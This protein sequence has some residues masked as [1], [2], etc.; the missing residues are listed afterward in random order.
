[1]SFRQVTVSGFPAL[2]LRGADVEAIVA[3]ALG[4]KLTNLRRLRGREWLWRSDQIPLA[5]GAPGASYVE[6]ADSGGWDECFP[7]VGP[8]PVPGAPD[9]PRLPDHGELWSARWESAVSEHAGGTTLTATTTG[10]RF[11]YEFQRAITL[12]AHEPIV[13]FRYRLRHLGG[14]PF[15]WIWSSHPLFN[16]QPGTTL[17]LPG[18]S[19]VRVDAAHGRPDAEHGDTLSWPGAVSGESTSF[20]VPAPTAGWALKLFA[21]VGRSGEAILTD[22]REGERLIFRMDPAAVPQIGVWIN[23]GGW[24]PTGRTPYFNMAVEPC[25]GAPDRLDQAVREWETAQLLGPGEERAWGLEV[26][27]PG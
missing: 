6:T 9:A 20:T 24:A 12:D 7:T 23:C 8:C 11:P 10:T 27:L 21:D 4:M 17:Q 26:H 22:P 19:Q 14:A 16:V 15:P 2:A 25:I 18:V 3:P 5:P 1:M 13:R